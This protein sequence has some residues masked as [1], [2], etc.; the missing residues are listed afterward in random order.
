M[1]APLRRAARA[2]TLGLLT[3]L[4]VA[5]TTAGANDDDAPPPPSGAPVAEAKIKY[6]AARAAFNEHD[7]SE[8]ADLFE[9][10]ADGWAGD[11]IA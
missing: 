4:S 7:W 6:E 11:P 2:L 9:E 3:T 10:V 1:K 5:C 8:A